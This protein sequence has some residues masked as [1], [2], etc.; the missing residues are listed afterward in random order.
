MKYIVILVVTLCLVACGDDFLNKTDPA[1]L[2]ASDFYKTEPQARQAV[3][4]VYG[5]LQGIISSQWLYNEFITDN[6][7]LHFNTGDRGQGPDTE[8]LEFWQVNS[9]TLNISSLYSSIYLSLVNINTTLAKLPA[10]TFDAGLKKQYEGELRFIRAY[11]YF[12]LVQYFGEVIIITEPLVT[13]SEAYAYE[14]QPVDAVY[15]LV[16]SDLDFAINA[17]PATYDDN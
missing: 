10:A 12:L 11:Y 15:T 4:G 9:G 17:L 8:A 13:P 16:Y 7:T 3:N 2:V 5:Q 1:T 6:T 14:R